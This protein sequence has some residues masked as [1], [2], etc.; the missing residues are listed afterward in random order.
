MPI[1]AKRKHDLEKNIE[2]S[3]DLLKQMEDSLRVESEPK[4]I[5]KL[6][7]DIDILKREISDF[8]KE[9]KLSNID[10]D[11]EVQRTLDLFIQTSYDRDQFAE[12]EQ[13]A[14]QL[15]LM[16]D[17]SPPFPTT[18]LSSSASNTII[19]P[20]ICSRSSG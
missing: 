4:R 12:L 18:G 11:P 7:A 16:A 13:I 9:L 6:K 8:D 10:L 17:D 5:A 20:A 14:D 15:M 3:Y 2:A 1:S 19:A